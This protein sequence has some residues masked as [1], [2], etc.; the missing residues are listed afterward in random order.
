MEHGMEQ[1]TK[2]NMEWNT[3]WNIKRNIE[4]NIKRNIEW[5]MERDMEWN[6]KYELIRMDR[7]SNTG[8][9]PGAFKACFRPQILL[10]NKFW[11]LGEKT[12][13]KNSHM[14]RLLKTRTSTSFILK[15]LPWQRAERTINRAHF[16]LF[17]LFLT[18]S[19]HSFKFLNT[20]PHDKK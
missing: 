16:E 13:P 5:I 15:E 1:N 4:W 2:W 19:E 10:K 3:E 11:N 8:H 20:G 9:R 6:R 18:I 14:S 7:G 17:G 12:I